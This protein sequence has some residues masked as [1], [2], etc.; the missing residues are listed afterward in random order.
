VKKGLVATNI[1]DCT[2]TSSQ[3]F[4]WDSVHNRHRSSLVISEGCGTW[5]VME[6]ILLHNAAKALVYS[7]HVANVVGDT[8]SD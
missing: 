7:D 2:F 4:S 5:I 3:V 8:I 1:H 6:S